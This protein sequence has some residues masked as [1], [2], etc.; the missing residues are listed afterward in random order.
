[1]NC[2][3]SA[4]SRL[5]HKAAW[6]WKVQSRLIYLV[7]VHDERVG[8]ADAHLEDVSLAGLHVGRSPLQEADHRQLACV[9]ILAQQCQRVALLTAPAA[10]AALQLLQLPVPAKVQQHTV[11][12][13]PGSLPVDMHGAVMLAWQH[14][15]RCRR[16]QQRTATNL[17]WAHELVVR[18]LGCPLI[19]LLR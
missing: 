11:K 16:S 12:A 18:Y 9:L 7:E 15:E 10:P 1:M 4:A 6:L 14:A 2:T 19:G 8:V 17:M 13:L 3:L 5:Q